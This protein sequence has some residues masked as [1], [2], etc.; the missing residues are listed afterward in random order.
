MNVMDIFF[1]F[2]FASISSN[3]FLFPSLV[4]P[5]VLH[6]Y[7]HINIVFTHLDHH[8]RGAG[9]SV[10]QA[11]KPW[12]V[13]YKVFPEGSFQSE[14]DCCHFPQAFWI[15][16]ALNSYSVLSTDAVKIAIS[17]DSQTGPSTDI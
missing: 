11:L 6:L 13:Y 17:A 14:G 8:H 12:S 9:C 1:I 5:F 4:K 10:H 3:F 15:M 7:L 2:L 16:C